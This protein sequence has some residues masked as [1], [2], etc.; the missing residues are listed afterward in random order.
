MTDIKV[1]DIVKYDG[2]LATVKKLPFNEHSQSITIQ[3]KSGMMSMVNKWSVLKM[4]DEYEG[5]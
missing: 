5:F 1:G 4:T 3:F 2:H